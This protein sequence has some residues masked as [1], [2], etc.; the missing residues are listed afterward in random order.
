MYILVCYKIPA[1]SSRKKKSTKSKTWLENLSEKKAT[2]E[3]EAAHDRGGYSIKKLDSKHLSLR[4]LSNP[5]P[6]CLILI[7]CGV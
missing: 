1:S 4:V 6:S 5:G 7:S 2:A 3:T